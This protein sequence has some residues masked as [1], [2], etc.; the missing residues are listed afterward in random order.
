M[1]AT[2]STTPP[3]AS[4]PRKGVLQQLARPP[5]VGLFAFV[6]VFLFQ[7]LGHTLMVG[8]EL[9]FGDE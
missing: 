7:G 1:T 5:L 2:A 3:A 6:V 4:A 9:I 8:M